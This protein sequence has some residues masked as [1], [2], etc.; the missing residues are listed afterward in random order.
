MRDI[1]FI[2]LTWNSKKF[3]DDCFGSIVSKCQ[4]EGI[5]FE[6]IVVDNGST[7]G[8]EA[9][10]GK[11][12]KENPGRFRSVLLGK[13]TGTTY[14]R[15]IGMR[16]ANGRNICI[17]DSDTE[18]GE[19]SLMDALS[20]LDRD[21]SIGLLVPRLL[22]PDQSV[23]NSVKR[24][25]TFWQK[26]SKIPK[27]VFGVQ[28]PNLDFYSEFPF[29]EETDVDTAISACWL[30]RRE[31]TDQ[32]GYLDEKIFYSPE[33]LD[34]SVRV[35]KAKKRIL[36]YPGFTVLHHTQQISHKK[37]FSKVSLSHFGG[38]LYYY[39]KHGGWFSAKGLYRQTGA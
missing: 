17:L 32:V 29:T 9:I 21:D 24:F 22:L 18:L 19:G 28:V 16:E 13:N 10:F 34:Y 35:R 31:L 39:R 12:Q 26:L 14:P 25:P 1:S 3:L 27:A 11:F 2:I 23:Q 8:S 15:N 38:L 4:S 7:D 20:R 5:D 33:D 6:I 30:F 36:F 37:P